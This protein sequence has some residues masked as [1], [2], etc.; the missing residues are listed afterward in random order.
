MLRAPT[1]AQYLDLL[2][3]ITPPEYWQPFF[4]DPAG[5]IALYRS[6]A[7]TFAILS[8]RVERAASRQLI[9][10]PPGLE[11][12]TSSSRATMTVVLRRT[13]N[14]DVGLLI[15]SE[16]AQLEGPNERQYLNVETARWLPNDPTPTRTVLFAS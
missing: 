13:R 2:K 14:L 1:L 11:N 4:A 5:A 16:T 9:I 12:P 8:Q 7:R 10:A 15:G 6:W 3:R